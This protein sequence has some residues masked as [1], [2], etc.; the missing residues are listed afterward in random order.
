[1]LSAIDRNFELRVS[2]HDQLAALALLKPVKSVS[3]HKQFTQSE[4][5]QNVPPDHLRRLN[6]YEG[7]L[8]E[9]VRFIRDTFPAVEELCLSGCTQLKHAD[10]LF[11]LP[12]KNLRLVDLPHNFSFDVLASLPELTNLS[13]YTALPWRNLEEIPA[14]DSLTSLHLADRVSASPDGISRWQMLEDLAIGNVPNKRQWNEIAA[15]PRL[16]SLQ[17]PSAHLLNAP[18]MSNVK[19]LWVNPYQSKNFLERIPDVFPHLET[20]SLLAR[21][22][23]VDLTPLRRMNG[24]Q[25]TVSHA[26]SVIGLDKLDPSLVTLYPRPR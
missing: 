16:Q 20:L 8:I 19:Y 2:N 17:L 25:I 21:G 5:I 18:S 23:T 9:G 7:Q 13:L 6:I 4:I 26:A 3:L 22:S 10:E 14:P 1:M 11:G 12:L 15:L 24:V